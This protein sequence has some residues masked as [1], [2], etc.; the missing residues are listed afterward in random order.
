MYSLSE[1]I[2][3]SRSHLES[4]TEGDPQRNLSVDSG[5]NT[6]TSMSID[7]VNTAIID[8]PNMYKMHMKDEGKPLRRKAC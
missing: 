6:F 7:P 3:H 2:D 8:I 5:A 4:A 1:L